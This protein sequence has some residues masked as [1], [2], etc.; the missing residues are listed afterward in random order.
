MEGHNTDEYR[1]GCIPAL[2]D[3]EVYLLSGLAAWTRRTG[4]NRGDYRSVSY[5]FMI[6]K[7]TSKDNRFKVL[8]TRS[9]FTES[10]HKDRR[11][12]VDKTLGYFEIDNE[13]FGVKTDYRA[14]DNIPVTH[15]LPNI[16]HRRAEVINKAKQFILDKLDLHHNYWATHEWGA[17]TWFT[18]GDEKELENYHWPFD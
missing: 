16:K 18:F 10:Y 4:S 12:F 3:C 17:Q 14:P 13:K 5:S 2:G 1:I 15:T 6:I 7:H 9:S 8:Y 11:D